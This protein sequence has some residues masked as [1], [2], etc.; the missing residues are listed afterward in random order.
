MP[1]ARHAEGPE[2]DVVVLDVV[3]A[4]DDALAAQGVDE[5]RHVGDVRAVAFHEAVEDGFERVETG[6][7]HREAPVAGLAGKRLRAAHP[8]RGGPFMFLR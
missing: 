3:L 5:A 8:S 1:S 6:R 4:P 7:R 2:G